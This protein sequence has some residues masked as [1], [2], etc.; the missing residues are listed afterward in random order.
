MISDAIFLA[1][2]RN[3]DTTEGRDETGLNTRLPSRFKGLL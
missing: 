1:E 3:K 2:T